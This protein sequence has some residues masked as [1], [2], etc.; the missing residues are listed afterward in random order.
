MTPSGAGTNAYPAD[1]GL[2]PLKS[3]RICTK[4]WSREMQLTQADRE[5][6]QRALGMIEGISYKVSGEASSALAVAVDMID[7]VLNSDK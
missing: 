3:T 6:I 5:T 1:I 7:G 2:P 4:G